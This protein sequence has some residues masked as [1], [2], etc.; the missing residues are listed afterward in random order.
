MTVGVIMDLIHQLEYPLPI[1]K[2]DT[3]KLIVETTVLGY[4]GCIN[5]KNA[6]G[7]ILNGFILS[8]NPLIEFENE[9]FN[10]NKVC[11][12]FN[13]NLDMYKNGDII[14]TS[15][16]IMSN[17]GEKIIPVIIKVVPHEIVTKEDIKIYTLKDFYSYSKKYPIQARRLFTSNEFMMWLI[18]LQFELIEIYERLI[19]DSNKERALENFFILNKMKNKVTL[20]VEENKIEHE[21]FENHREIISGEIIVKKSGWGFVDEEISSK[22]NALWLKIH[23]S[24]VTSSDFRDTD[25]AVITYSIDPILIVKKKVFEKIIIGENTA[26]DL[27]V[28]VAPVFTAVLKK[29]FLGFKDTGEII[30]TNN[31][32]EEIMI[33]V[34]SKENFVKFECS[35]HLVG[36]NARIPFNIKLSPFLMAQMAIKKQPTLSAEIY[37]KT[38]I[39]KKKVEK[40]LYIT[41]GEYTD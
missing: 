4:K 38:T 24:R 18:N 35:N 40:I 37:L 3:D 19:K 31:S 32:K 27:R 10:E 16:V 14:Q 11:V 12:N 23:S 36:S 28:R 8:K 2:T 17:G 29:E 25:K 30:I 15:I 41:V 5:I 20:S 22:Y 26:V 6:G 7:G 9:K 1:L 13:I 21:V 39:N 33:N 34:F